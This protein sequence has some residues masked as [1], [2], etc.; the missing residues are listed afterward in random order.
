M[1]INPPSRPLLAAGIL[2]GAGF[3]G[4]FDG[5]VFQQLLQWHHMLTAH[6]DYPADTVAGLEVNT[7]WDGIFHS[8]TWLLSLAGLG[9]L[10]GLHR[11]YDLGWSAV[12]V[13]GLLMGW[14]GF[15][16]VEGIINHQVLGIHHVRDDLGGPWAWDIGFLV[17]GGVFLVAGWMLSR[18]RPETVPGVEGVPASRGRS[19]GEIRAR[20]ERR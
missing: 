13:G 20:T 7:L 3:G 4:F 11:R 10:W 15:N 18:G 5:I 2:L 1:H 19:Q 14:G 16:V 6:G 9:L 8:A 17:W 12:L